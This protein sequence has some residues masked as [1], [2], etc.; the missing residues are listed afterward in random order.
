MYNEAYDH[1]IGVA[2]IIHY[3]L[4]IINI[5]T[6]WQAEMLGCKCVR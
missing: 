2:F 3:K 5:L 1:D 4:Y 6:L